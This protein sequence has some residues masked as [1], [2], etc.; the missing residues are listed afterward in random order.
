[1]Y[2]RQTP[3][4]AGSTATLVAVDPALAG[5][6]L[7]P[8]GAP[9]P[10]FSDMV[11][12]PIGALRLPWKRQLPTPHYREV[13]PS[14]GMKKKRRVEANRPRLSLGAGGKADIGL[15]VELLGHGHY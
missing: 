4:S 10:S 11:F 9:A 12:P 8:M 13:A 7:L 6:A 1:M 2:K 14:W 5:V 15:V 3:A